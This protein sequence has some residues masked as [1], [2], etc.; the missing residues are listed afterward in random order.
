MDLHHATRG[1]EDGFSLIE[2]LVVVVIIGV[3]AAIAIPTFLIQRERAWETDASTALRNAAIA[4]S[5][6]LHETNTYVGTIAALSAEGFNLSPSVSLTVVS[7]DA[8]GYCME[9]AHDSGGDAFRL[10]SAVGTIERSI[11]C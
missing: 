6:V 3:L 5:S 4:Q 10:D 1:D 7:A 9:A 8:S 11:A 2:L